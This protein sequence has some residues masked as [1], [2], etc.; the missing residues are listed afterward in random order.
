MIYTDW[1]HNRVWS[2][3]YYK[4]NHIHCPMLCPPDVATW[5]LPLFSQ[6]TEGPVV[7][8]SLANNESGTELA[9]TKSW[10]TT[11]PDDLLR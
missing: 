8:S 9:A 2:V 5:S 3:C 7:D 1:L 4:E 6:T 11:P 10:K